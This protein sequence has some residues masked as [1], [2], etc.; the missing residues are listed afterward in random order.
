MIPAHSSRAKGRVERL[1][2]TLQ[3]RLV[4]GLRLAGMAT[5]MTAN[6]FLKIWLPHYNRRVTVQPAQAAD[7]HLPFQ[8]SR[9]LN[10]ILWGQATWGVRQDWIVATTTGSCIKSISRPGRRECWLKT[11]CMGGCG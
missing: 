8:G 11:I 6:R 2:K 5:I 9:E 3:E 7:L 10:R 1:F 4:K